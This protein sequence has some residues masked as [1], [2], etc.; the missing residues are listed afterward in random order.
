MFS[1]L[2]QYKGRKA[3]HLNQV[4]SQYS[5][6]FDGSAGSIIYAFSWYSASHCRVFRRFWRAL[7]DTVKLLLFLV[8]LLDVS[9]LSL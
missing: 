7:K 2:A 6:V 4:N 1:Y 9:Y 5:L 3:F 8:S